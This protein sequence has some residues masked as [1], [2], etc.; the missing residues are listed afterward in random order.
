MQEAGDPK[1]IR[2]MEQNPEFL[3]RAIKASPSPM[4]DPGLEEIK[5]ESLDPEYSD[6]PI[7]RSDEEMEHDVEHWLRE[8]EKEGVD[9]SGLQVK[10]DSKPSNSRPV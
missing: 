8:F 10:A 1:L 5:R 7:P 6:S 4:D 2:A 9:A 3:E